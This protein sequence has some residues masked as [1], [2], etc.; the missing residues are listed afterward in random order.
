MRISLLFAIILSATNG[1]LC[2]N[3]SGYEVPVKVETIYHFNSSVSLEKL[4]IR[5]SGEAIVG[6]D[7]SP[8]L[9]QVDPDLINGSVRHIHTFEGY[10][11]VHG[12][13]EV[14]DD[15]FYVAASNLSVWTHIDVLGSPSIF[16]VNMT[17]F[18]E[19]PARV[20]EV[21]HFPNARI[22]NGMEVISKEEGLIYVGDSA[23]GVINILNVNTGHHYMA[24]NNSYTTIYPLDSGNGVYGIHLFQPQND[25]TKYLYL[26]NFQQGIIAR[27]PIHPSS[28]LPVGEPKVVVSNLTTVAEFALDKEGNIFAALLSLNQFVRVDHKTKE[29]LVLA[30]GPDIDTYTKAISV[31]FGRTESDKGKLYAVTI[32]GFTALHNVGAGLFRLDTEDMAVV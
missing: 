25:S 31:A 15:Q 12:I 10:S 11:V 5:K 17:G 27:V 2:Q 13:L 24:I 16:H 22:L 18:P 3:A 14:E 4:A 28:G 9:Y 30:G 23:L 29:V 21:V 7:N 8:N 6:F 32:G 20:R 26:S 19:H 1:I